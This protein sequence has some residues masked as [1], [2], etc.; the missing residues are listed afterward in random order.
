[1]ADAL[2]AGVAWSLDATI[3]TR[4]PRDFL[5]M[6]VPVLGHGQPVG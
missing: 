6:D 4:N 3:V 1:V 2:I 5:G